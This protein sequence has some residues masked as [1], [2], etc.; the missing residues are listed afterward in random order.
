MAYQ[1]RHYHS[2]TCRRE[3]RLTPGTSTVGSRSDYIADVREHPDNKNNNIDFYIAHTPE[4][5]INALYSC[6]IQICIRNKIEIKKYIK[7]HSCHIILN[8]KSIICHESALII[9]III[10]ILYS[11][12]S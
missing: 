3:V 6:T 8:L 11:A 9:K 5:Q 2:Q 12:Y 10:Y 7:K 4:I 1:R